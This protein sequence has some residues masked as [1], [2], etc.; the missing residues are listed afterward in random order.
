MSA[1]SPQEVR[2][3]QAI[4]DSLT[5]AHIG[6]MT[7]VVRDQVYRNG[8]IDVFFSTNGEDAVYFHRTI[9][10][11]VVVDK[12]ALR[13]SSGILEIESSLVLPSDDLKGSARLLFDGGE[14]ARFAMPLDQTSRTSLRRVLDAKLSRSFQFGIARVTGLTPFELVSA[15]MSSRAHSA[16][17]NWRVSTRAIAPDCAFDAR[18]GSPCSDDQKEAVDGAAREG[19]VLESY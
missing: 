19:L 9:A 3:H 5:G 1:Q 14:I 6:E 15:M 13:E 11:A 17:A 7:V 16:P 2:H 10:P 4:D 8:S 18:F 12:Y